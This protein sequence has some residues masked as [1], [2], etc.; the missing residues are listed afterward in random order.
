MVREL[1]LAVVVLTS[2]IQIS[3]EAGQTSNTKRLS[4]GA[5]GLLA[6]ASELDWLAGHWRGEGLGGICE[7]V[8]LPAAGGSLIGTFRLV[9]DDKVVFYEF[10]AIVEDAG[11]LVLRLKHFN[12][13]VTG[14]E[15]KD[16][17][18]DF[19]LVE[20]GENEAYF[21][22]L[23]YRR[24]DSDRLEIFLAMRQKDGT[25]REEAFHFRRVAY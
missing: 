10:L 19:R 8:W 3:A 1:V 24:V 14:W 11:R 16:D 5:T 2:L 6:S 23:T 15:E 22:G 25:L 12:P 7:E 9:K 13:D 21:S 20:L 4:A 17:T 18:V